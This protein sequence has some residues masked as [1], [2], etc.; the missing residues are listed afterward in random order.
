[1]FLNVH[2]KY[3]IYGKGDECQRGTRRTLPK[4]TKTNE[5][6]NEGIRIYIHES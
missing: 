6:M 4:K 3:A 2:R 5:N 1:M